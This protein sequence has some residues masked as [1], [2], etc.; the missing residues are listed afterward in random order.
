MGYQDMSG[1]AR[2][3]LPYFSLHCCL[4]CLERSNSRFNLVTRETVPAIKYLE[5]LTI[6]LTWKK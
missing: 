5:L 6:P 4:C 3:A 1:N 2:T